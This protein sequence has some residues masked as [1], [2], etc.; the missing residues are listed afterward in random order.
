MAL[1][2]RFL[3]GHFSFFSS[4]YST[5]LHTSV[6]CAAWLRMIGHTCYWLPSH[7]LLLR[8]GSYSSAQAHSSVK[9]AAM[10]AGINLE[11]FRSLPARPDTFALEAETLQKAID[12]DIAAGKCDR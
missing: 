2:M 8:L 4:Q 7:S 6:S 12:K 9:K 5:T 1:R 11:R 10:I 3:V